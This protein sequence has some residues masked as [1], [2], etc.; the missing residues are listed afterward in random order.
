MTAN[1]YKNRI[2]ELE[3]GGDFRGAYEILKEA[4]SEF[5]A[6]PFFIKAEIYILFRLGRLEE[7]R[8]NAEIRVEQFKQDTFFLRTYLNILSNIKN[9]KKDIENLVDKILIWGVRDEAFLVFLAGLTGRISGSKKARDVLIRSISLMPESQT[10]KKMLSETGGDGGIE[11][12]FR[13]YKK[14]FGDKD[15]ER[16]INEIEMIMEMPEYAGDYELNLYLAGLYK[17]AGRLDKSI[18]IYK[19]LLTNKEN[20]FARKMLGYAYYKKGD[21]INA[22]VCLKDIFLKYPF[23]HYLYTTIFKICEG[24]R[25]YQT[26]ESLFRKALASNPDAKHLYGLIKK[27]EK[28]GKR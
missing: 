3:K 9:T 20:E 6:N 24:L 4:M 11:S 18:E 15:T 2:I 13:L 1:Q 10:L 23:D 7:A 8:Q 21:Q 19:K 5:P 27:A 16:A 14:K 12:K 17:E 26:L 25:D 28:W 22:L